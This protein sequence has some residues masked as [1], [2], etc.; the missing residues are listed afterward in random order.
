L[1]GVK[2]VEVRKV[3]VGSHHETRKMVGNPLMLGGAS[4]ERKT[5]EEM[6]RT[7]VGTVVEEIPIVTLDEEIPQAG[8]P[9]PDF[10]KIDIEGWEIEALR[11]ARNT[12]KLYKPALFLEMHGETIREKR[13]KVTEIVTFLWEINYRRIRHIESGTMITPE[14]TSIAMEGHLYCQTT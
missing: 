11:G 14:N 5:V 4:V 13:R 6:L 7:G 8:L 9:A 1:N 2:N 12:L 10:I 3:G